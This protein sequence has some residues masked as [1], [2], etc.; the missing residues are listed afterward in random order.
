MTNVD[1]A[2]GDPTIESI[3]PTALKEQIDTGENLIILDTRSEADFNQWHIEHPNIET[4]NYPYFNMLD[5]IP[6]DLLSKLSPNKP[7]TVLCAKGE[8]S[9]MIAD[10][11]AAHGYTVSHLEQGMNGWA[12]IYEYTE[13]DVEA[14]AT[15]AQYNRPASGCLGYLVVSGDDAAVIDP[16]RAFTDTYLQDVRMMGAELKYVLD[17]HIHADHIS[18]L[19]S[20]ATNTAAIPILPNHSVSRGV[21][22]D[23]PIHTIGDGDTLT[24]GEIELQA[25]HTPG[26]T[27]GMTS[28]AVE[29]VLFTGDSLFTESVARPDLEDP[30]AAQAAAITLYESLH[31]KILARDEYQRVAPA[32]YSGGAIPHTD[33]SYSA[34]LGEVKDSMDLLSMTEAEFVEY[35]VSDMPPRPANYE[36]IIAIN[37]GQ[38]TADG[39]TAF[40]LELG[41]NNCAASTE[42]KVN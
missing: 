3:T 17:T 33:G 31:E 23:L 32:H 12:R 1:V 16:L 20:L 5:G 24:I 4:I 42:A 15:I 6:Q 19:R 26:H 36:D 38:T 40:E 29:D 11:L 2:E 28:Y 7:I 35:I 39:S 25:V 27:T 18:G 8:A 37:L 9:K 34:S 41:P 30:D 10:Q 14:D 13:L 21:D 22:Y